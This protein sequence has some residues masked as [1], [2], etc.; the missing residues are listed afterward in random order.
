MPKKTR[1]SKSHP[2]PWVRRAGKEARWAWRSSRSWRAD[3]AQATTTLYRL[4]LIR[5]AKKAYHH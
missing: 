5:Q 3:A 4:R 1:T 2:P